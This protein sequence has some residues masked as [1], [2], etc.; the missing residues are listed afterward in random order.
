MRVSNAHRNIIGKAERGNS[1]ARNEGGC[2]GRGAGVG[3]D[4]ET[5]VDRGVVV[6]VA[7]GVAVA[8][9]V[10]VGLCAGAQYL[11]PVLK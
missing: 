1:S 6:A 2:Y 7:V 10:G 9:A 4:R 11:P 5:G 8:V 3:L